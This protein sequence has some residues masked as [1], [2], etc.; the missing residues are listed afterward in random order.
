MVR[1]CGPDRGGRSEGDRRNRRQEIRA[2]RHP[3]CA[4][5][6][7][8]ELGQLEHAPGEHQ[9]RGIELVVLLTPSRTLDNGRQHRSRPITRTRSGSR[10][11]QRNARRSFPSPK[12]TE[13]V[14]RRSR[15]TLTDHRLFPASGTGCVHRIWDMINAPIS[16]IHRVSR[17]L[18]DPVATPPA[19]DIQ[20]LNVPGIAA[21]G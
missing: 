13:K 2:I 7:S 10:F 8:S 20:M 18:L 3:E 9:Q 4:P 5:N 11:G 12:S 6:L 14:G 17:G 1:I 16:S 21:A 19:K 15:S